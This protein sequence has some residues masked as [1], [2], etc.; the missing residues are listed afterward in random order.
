VI[1]LRLIRHAIAL[2][3]A[4]NFARAA[5]LLNL[6]QPS[7]SRSIALLEHALGV[8]LFDRGRMGV[9]PTAYGRL[10]LE[11]GEALLG[12][13]AELRRQ[14]QLLAGLEA[15]YLVIGAGPYASET[16]VAT[17][18]VR[19]M[20]AHPRLRMQIVTTS[21]V[22]IVEKVL[23][24]Q[25]D[26]GVADV[27]RCD[28]RRFCVQSFGPHDVLLA[29]RPGHPLAGRRNLALEDVLAFPLVSSLFRGD[30]ATTVS[31]AGTL[32]G[33]DLDTGDFTPAI[34][35]NSAS[36]ARRI[37]RDTDALAPGTMAMLA[38][39]LQAG[40]L[41]LVDFHIAAMR[42]RYSLLYLRDRTL[43]PAALAFVSILREVETELQADVRKNEA[44]DPRG[45]RGRER[46][47]G[48]KKHSGGR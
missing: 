40:R 27:G 32:G 37:A 30:A 33:V 26:V 23:A 10:L 34:N 47:D 48:A 25:F 29:C 36:M 5:D 15:G 44:R 20:A 6:T 28:D 17:A 2:G 4:R 12:S 19:L 46:R 7:L 13:E 11:Q 3:R 1:E 21:P 42:T 41:Q 9:E 24:G 14:L 18:V 16:S 38:P 45:V 35:V 43:A 8:P 31:A 22:E 39:D